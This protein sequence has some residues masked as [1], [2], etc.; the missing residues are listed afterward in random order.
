MKKAIYYKRVM[1][2]EQVIYGDI[3]FIINFSMDFLTLYISARIM[4]LK[5]RTFY[6]IAA[7]LIGAVYGV[8]SLFYSINNIISPVIHITVSLLMC[9]IVF[10]SEKK[11]MFI[12]AAILFWGI[13]F[14]LGGSMTAIYNLINQNEKH[15]YMNGGV[16][17]VHSEIPPVV[18]GV[19]AVVSGII[20]FA[21]GQI[22]KRKKH[23]KSVFVQAVY[24]DNKIS[25]ECL[26]DSGNL[27]REPMSGIPV[28]VTRY[29]ILE[30][31]LTAELRHIFKHNDTL[32]LSGLRH[33]HIK[34]VRLIPV[35]SI[36]YSG[37]MLGF[38]PE[39]TI[40]NDSE[41]EVCIAVETKKTS[42]YGGYDAIAPAEVL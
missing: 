10:G 2:M 3:L 26:Y 11:G 37:I 30:P 29:E 32:R 12:R 35:S 22:I 16:T 20:S 1:R 6:L 34:H 31:I 41:R 42:D 13:S 14:A 36:G 39:K 27:L 40:I 33:A 17:A 25:F 28:I 19:L 24:G 38:I 4:N 21:G 5:T 9:F 18:I 23:E 8:L 7:S 15:V